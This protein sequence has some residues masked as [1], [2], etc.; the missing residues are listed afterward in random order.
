MKRRILS[1]L[2]VMVMLLTSVPVFATA[3][4]LAD[5]LSPDEAYM[6]EL[7]S[8]YADYD[9]DVVAIYRI[10][11]PSNGKHHYTDDA[12]ERDFLANGGWIYEGIAW[13]APKTGDPIYRLYNPSNDNHL[14]TTDAVEKDFLDANGWN[15][16]GLLTYSSHSGDDGV[17]L[18]RVFNPYVELN[19]HHYTDSLEECDYLRSNGWNVEGVAWY[20]ISH[21]A[22][23]GTDYTRAQ[24]IHALVDAYGYPDNGEVSDPS[25]PDIAGTTYEADIEIAVAYGLLIPDG[26]AFH[27]DEPATREFAAVTA[28]RSLGYQT[29]QTIDC[30]DAD[31]ITCTAEAAT[32]VDLGLLELEDNKFLP[33]RPLTEEEGAAILVK[34]EE[35]YDTTGTDE[36]QPGPDEPG[37]PGDG[38]DFRDGVVVLSS[39]TSR[40][41][42]DSTVS[43]PLTDQLQDL[44]AGDIVVLGTEK[45]YKVTS[46]VT[47]GDNVVISY[48]TPDLPE[49]LDSLNLSGEAYMDFSQFEPAEGVNVTYNSAAENAAYYGF[50]DEAFDVPANEVGLNINVVLDGDVDLGNNWSLDYAVN[51]AIPSVAYKFDIDFGFLSANVKNAYLKFQSGVSVEA[52]LSNDI[53]GSDHGAMVA[54]DLLYKYIPL[55]RVPLVGIDGIGAVV[56]IDLV[57]NA[58][59]SF[60]FAYNL[61]GT[62]GCQVLNN[63]PRNISSLQSSC[64]VGVMGE[65][66]V[67]PKLGVVAE[68]FEKDLISFTAE[69]GARLGGSV[70]VRSTGVV[71]VDGGLTLYAELDAFERTL[72]DDLLDIHTTWTIWDEHN[73]P[74][75]LKKHFENMVE[76]PECTYEGGI[77]RGTVANADDRTQYIENARIDI[78]KHSDMSLVTTVYSD[79]AGQYSANLPGGTYLIAI[80]ADG[81]IPFDCL[82]TIME[83]QE[84]YLETLLMVEGDE[85]DPRI[86]D[87]GGRIINS[88]NGS[89]ISNVKITIRKGWNM[90]SG[91]VIDTVYTDSSGYYSTQL[92]LGNYTL[93]LERT[94]YVSGLINIAVTG[95]TTPNQNG[96]MVPDGTG[97][98]PTGD[99]RIRMSWL[100]EPA[101]LDSHLWGPGVDGGRFHTYYANKTYSY[102]GTTR[103]FLDL[104]DTYYEGPETTTIYDM[105]LTGVYSFYVHDYTNRSR[106]GSTVMANSGVRV[107]VLIGAELVATYHI[108]TNSSGNVWHVFDYNADTG[109]L[110]A[111][112]A[113]CDQANASMVGYTGNAA[114]LAPAPEKETKDE[115]DPTSV[116]VPETEETTPATE[117]PAEPSEPALPAEPSEP[118]LPAEPSEPVAPAEPSEPALPA[119]PSEPALPA[120]PGEDG[121]E[122]PEEAQTV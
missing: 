35:A 67:G 119:E 81:Y 60:E 68:V 4:E 45:A 78:Y 104:D 55:G 77:I 74:L 43:M 118:A 25:Y 28:V 97:E 3:Q 9:G 87:V 47:E 76:V 110:T 88:V 23:G 2:M 80:S 27:P 18:Y 70:H 66:K 102:D 108:P 91:D 48:T 82:Q 90:T 115:Q 62:I 40:E 30:D 33:N 103:A 17:P 38:Y 14:Y 57:M 117:V 107:E 49:F 92:P 84:T 37:M 106:T 21:N 85:D 36:P 8:K 50:M 105:N 65:I 54:D 10:Y 73:S 51:V 113:F 95:L 6:E 61:A 71:C 94:G 16:E 63:Q 7:R 39:E 56:E 46:A 89:P 26:E 29:E 112:N 32:A 98:I 41:D 34:L 121:S 69:A 99:L 109:T 96:S 52:K 100:S 42:T 86:M 59:G 31:E 19:P 12:E 1:L 79:A 111:V 58:E 53:D 5:R 72:I 13:Y 22:G 122:V 11:N 44:Q 101:D 15:Y 93:Y 20:G 83:N 114:Y 116:T 64:S 120:E 75:K 24:W